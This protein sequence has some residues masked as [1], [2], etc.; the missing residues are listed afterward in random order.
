MSL[1]DLP[2]AIVRKVSATI[3]DLRRQAPGAKMVGEFAVKHV[4]NEATK[5]INEVTKPLHNNQPPNSQ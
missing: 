2:A 3:S 4:A 5:K 1:F